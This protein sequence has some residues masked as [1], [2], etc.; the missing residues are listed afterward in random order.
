[1][2]LQVTFLVAA[3]EYGDGASQ[4]Q[5][6]PVQQFVELRPQSCTLRARAST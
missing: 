2:S 5:P 1:L 3:R 6:E 4:A